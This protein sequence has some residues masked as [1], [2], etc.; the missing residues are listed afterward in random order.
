[1]RSFARLLLLVWCTVAFLGVAG[2]NRRSAAPTQTM[3]PPS[4]NAAT[5]E[6]KK[7]VPPNPAATTSTSASSSSASESSLP[8]SVPASSPPASAQSKTPD[9]RLALALKDL[10]AQRGSRGEVLRLPNVSFGPGQAEFEA[11]SNTDLNQ[12]VTLLHDYP[13]ALLI[14]DGY[15]DNRGSERLN[16]RL[17]LQRAKS[18]QQALVADGLN[19][20][21]IRTRGLG[22]ADPIADNSTR[23]G[24]DKNRRVEVVFSNSAGTFASAGDQIT[25]G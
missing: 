22:S 20:T 12:V 2:C 15:T 16:E 14:I 23:Q 25:A 1:M 6:S 19:A 4:A 11:G 9:E 8:H 21:R 13:N 3:Q 10:G 17:S 18:V 7:I 5:E 24:R